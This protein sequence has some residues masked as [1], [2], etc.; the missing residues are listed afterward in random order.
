M[1]TGGP[2]AMAGPVGRVAG[3]GLT[4]RRLQ[5][6]VI[7]LV[8]LVSCAA[9]VLALGLVV[10]SQSPFNHAFAAQHGADVTAVVN[11]GRASYD[12]LAATA[13]LAGVTAAA[14]P[15]SQVTTSAEAPAPPQFG[16]GMT[17]LPDITLAGRALP[18]GPVDQVV[19]QSGHWATAPGQV[20]LA[21]G[22]SGPQI[23]LPLGAHI[24]LNGLP[25]KPT[26]TV[27]GTANSVTGSADGWVVPAEIGRLSSPSTP[28]SEQM[29]YRFASASTLTA[30]HADAAE[31]TRALPAG[32]VAGT[33]NYLA[34]RDNETSNAAP[35]VPFLVAF[36][37]LG[38]VM[39]VLI[40]ANV[41]SGAVVAG[42]R[43][44]GVLKSIGFTPG[45]VMAAYTGQV[46]VSA[47]VGCVA[48]VVLG[49]I[50]AMPV[51]AQ[52]ASV[53]QVGALHVP[54][55]VD[56][57]VPA[58]MCCLVA[59]AAVL[60]ALRAGRLSA[61]QAIATGRAPRTGRG[62][63]AHRLLGRLP[64]PRPATIGLAAP[65]A[66][67]ARTA[68]T[69]TAIALGATAVTLAVGLTSSLNDV[70]QGLSHAAAEPVQIQ[71]PGGGGP[72]PGITAVPQNCPPG[73]VVRTPKG[74]HVCGAGGPQPSASAAQHAVQAALAEQPGTARYVAE[75]NQ[76]ASVA[77]LTQ[78]V[79]V[80]AFRGNATWTG[81]DL[82]SGRWYG[83]PGQVVVGSRFLAVT[84]SQVGDTVTLLVNG[85]QVPVKIVGQA[86]DTRNNGL[87]VLTGWST[88]ASA[89]P[90][91]APDTYDV[92]LQS[93]TSATA[94]AR[95]LQAKLGS[96]Y[97][98]SIN[99]SH[100][101]VLD[102]MLALIG[103]L[104][105]LLAI[106]AGL[107]VLNTVVLNTRERVHDLGVFKVIGMTPR[108]TTA[109][110]VCWVA[111]VGLLAGLIAVPAGI[112]LHRVVLP[113]MASAAGTGLPPSYLAV[114]HGVE[115]GT[116]ALAGVGIA[117]A[118]A[119]LPASWAAAIR[120]GAA[121]R[122]E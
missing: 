16:G 20:V 22:Q 1:S 96:D 87:S 99:D 92:G 8:L 116:L 75:A 36:G 35:F 89:E 39:S 63:A 62:Y 9:S 14:G 26:L 81:Y 50:L 70:V 77:G 107:G 108:Q 104:T 94:Y 80:T 42:Y 18:G 83:G 7:G 59:I 37:V 66:R 113:A 68:M 21:T 76:Q 24:T 85:K 12:Q 102:V 111:G 65:F 97:F 64:L 52:T 106:V 110:A 90:G 117:I 3:G 44:I 28:V 120:T 72:G 95:S 82:I 48:G 69:M 15:F 100:S 114:Y 103:T 60:P 17:Q 56:V 61:V 74:S 41:V 86:F 88:L 79:S 46:L 115:L 55:W 58:V 47:I 105:L 5:T 11:P 122:A 25:G 109:M 119:L 32:A 29:L 19:L 54:V 10:E 53:Y 23:G 13:H 31:L 6:V 67:P 73:A 43:R 101:D 34:A 78:P 51:L 40:T 27:V 91:L 93:G 38:L 30:L 121:L 2:L 45:Q 71:V 49:N 98:V 57:M 4:R 33:Q 84:G 112:A 118:G